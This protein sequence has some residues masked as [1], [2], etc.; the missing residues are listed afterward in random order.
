MATLL[1]V[2]KPS[3][4]NFFSLDWTSIF[5]KVNILRLF[6][7]VVFV[8]VVSNICIDNETYIVTLLISRIYHL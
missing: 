5:M 2:A 3:S 4:A 7:K 6:N 8:V 1:S